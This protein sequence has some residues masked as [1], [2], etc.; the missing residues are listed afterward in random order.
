VKRGILAIGLATLALAV[1]ATG[2]GGDSEA[3]ITKAEFVDQANAVCKEILKE[4]NT[5]VKEELAQFKK[6]GKSLELKENDAIA[7]IAVALPPITELPDKLRQLEVP[8]GE[9][10]QVEAIIDSYATGVSEM[11]EDPGNA[12]GSQYP[13]KEGDELAEKYGLNVCKF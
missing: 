1:A 7:V 6:E 13:F 4:K 10:D 11:E 2:C 8:E 12:F 3:S 5:L 9:E